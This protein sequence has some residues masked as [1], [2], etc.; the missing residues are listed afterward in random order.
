MPK[1]TQLPSDVKVFLSELWKRFGLKSPKYFRIWNKVGYVFATSGLLPTA[2][3]KILSISI[4]QYPWLEGILTGIGLGIVFL[5]QQTVVN[6]GVIS[7]QTGQLPFTEKKKLQGVD[8]TPL[9]TLNQLN[10]N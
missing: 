1:I 7:G 5:A 10:K 4:P 2:S 3:T 9:E 6:A 8:P